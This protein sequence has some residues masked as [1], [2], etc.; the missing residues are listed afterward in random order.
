MTD[1][2]ALIDALVTRM[3]PV[4]RLASPLAR[5]MVW[6]ALASVVIAAIVAGRGL[7]PELLQAMAYPAAAI[8]WIASIATGMLAAYAVFQ[9]SVPGRSAAWAWLP[10]P[11]LLFWLTG[12]GWGCLGEIERIGDS[13]LAFD[14]NSSECAWA[15]ALTSLPLALVMLFMVRHAG[16]VRPALTAMLAGL[17]TAA[18]SAAGVS[19]IH[20]GETALMVLLWH[21]GA[22]ALIISLSGL[23][24]R[25][26]F[27]WTGST[28][29]PF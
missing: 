4:K 6:L 25:R 11:A 8:E 23:M 19:L 20:E 26:V 24:S 21:L 29:G 3:T 1:T 22:V 14:A 5:S 16:P 18:L 2:N 10:L 27:S 28:G 13:A 7:R 9:V 17:S 15:I 12:L